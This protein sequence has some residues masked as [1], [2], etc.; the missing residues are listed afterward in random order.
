MNKNG[1]WGARMTGGGFGGCAIGLIEEKD[2]KIQIEKILKAFVEKGYKTPKI[3][4]ATAS[5]G[6]EK[7]MK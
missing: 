2:L 7:I 1:A 5:S 4:V 6:A 3:M